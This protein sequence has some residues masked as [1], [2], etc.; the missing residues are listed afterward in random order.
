MNSS[1]ESSAEYINK[2]EARISELELTVYERAD[3]L[4]SS[5]KPS[6]KSSITNLGDV[7]YQRRF[8]IQHNDQ[9]KAL[10]RQLAEAENKLQVIS[11]RFQLFYLIYHN[12]TKI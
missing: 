4:S 10:T 5:F 9:I 1:L 8:E 7:A 11:L 3:D 2:C 12:F 6:N